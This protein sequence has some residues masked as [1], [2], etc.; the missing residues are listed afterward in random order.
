MGLLLYNLFNSQWFWIVVAIWGIVAFASKK[1][2]DLAE[3]ILF[4][5]SRTPIDKDDPDEMFENEGFYPGKTLRYFA[6]FL[7]RLKNYLTEKK[8]ELSYSDNPVSFLAYFILLVAFVA[9][10]FADWIAIAN[11]LS[12]FFAVDMLLTPFVIAG[13][14]LAVGIATFL[15]LIIGFF[16]LYQAKADDPIMRWG[17][18][19]ERESRTLAQKISFITVGIA[20]LVGFFIGFQKLTTLGYIAPNSFIDFFAQFG[21][22]VMILINGSLSAGLIF[23]EALFGVLVVTLGLAWVMIVILTIGRHFLDFAIRAFIIGF[24]LVTYYIFTPITQL[25]EFVKKIFGG[26]S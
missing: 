4:L 25:G 22:H 19:P 15:S 11:G 13:Y 14:G 16:V 20:L 18:D 7:D 26:I 8:L 24:D 9:F 23:M 10:A 21:V 5:V 17:E 2:E 3:R 12:T 6:A 1:R